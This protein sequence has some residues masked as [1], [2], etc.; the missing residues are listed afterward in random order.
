MA[1]PFPIFHSQLRITEISG[2]QIITQ[3]LS[4]DEN[5]NQFSVL[6]LP[7]PVSNNA[8]SYLITTMAKQ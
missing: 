8:F 5:M 3:G 4:E 1:L 2:L 6:N 7:G